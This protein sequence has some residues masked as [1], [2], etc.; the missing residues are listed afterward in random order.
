MPHTCP[1]ATYPVI[2]STKQSQPHGTQ[3]P[4]VKTQVTINYKTKNGM[5]NK[6]EGKIEKWG[7]VTCVGGDIK[8]GGRTSQLRAEDDRKKPC[9]EWEEVMLV[10]DMLVHQSWQQRACSKN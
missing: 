3:S 4:M 1:G 9:E 2:S 7:G 10:R 6:Q 5:R 8:K